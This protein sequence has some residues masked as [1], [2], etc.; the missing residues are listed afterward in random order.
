MIIISLKK[1]ITLIFRFI[2]N[3]NHLFLLLVY[4]LLLSLNQNTLN[5]N[6]WFDYSEL[7]N[8]GILYN[9]VTSVSGI[10]FPILYSV[11]KSELF[12]ALFFSLIF[13]FSLQKIADSLQIEKK[14][15][16]ISFVFF[17]FTSF[18]GFAFF[19]Y[20]ILTFI[21]IC[22]LVLFILNS[23]YLNLLYL[24][25]FT[26]FLLM[27]R[28]HDGLLILS[29]TIT[30]LL[31]HQKNLLYIIT[32]I[33]IPIVISNFILFFYDL[34]LSNYLENVIF[35]AKDAKTSSIFALLIRP[36]INIKNSLSYI[37]FY[38]LLLS[39]LSLAFIY[40]FVTI[41]NNFIIKK[42][43]FMILIVMCLINFAQF[44]LFIELV[45][46]I[47]LS[48][49]FFSFIYEMQKI[50]I[51]QY[52]NFIFKKF[53]ST[54]FF[55]LT[56][57]FSLFYIQNLSAGGSFLFCHNFILPALCLLFVILN[58]YERKHTFI[59][60]KNFT[61][62]NAKLTLFLNLFFTIFI[63]GTV[64]YK[65][66]KPY[67]WHSIL[68]PPVFISR[69]NCSVNDQSIYIDKQSCLFLHKINDLI[70]DNKTYSIMGYPFSGINRLLAK[71]LYKHHVQHFYDFSSEKEIERLIMDTTGNDPVDIIVYKY[72]LN[73]LM[74]HIQTYKGGKN[75]SNK[76][77]TYELKI[78][79]KNYTVIDFFESYKSKLLYF[80][81]VNNSLLKNEEDLLYFQKHFNKKIYTS[82]QY[83]SFGNQELNRFTCRNI[84]NINK[85]FNDP[86]SFYK[87]YSIFCNVL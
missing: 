67:E 36:I 76:H 43:F 4:V 12:V 28:I 3:F 23:C 9:D 52:L 1:E 55:L 6:I 2:S 17:I 30:F 56:L 11:L 49:Y 15:I 54:E 40:L 31:L 58:N 79:H 82:L 34:D 14:K 84:E 85:F 10:F 70:S 24:S 64:L 48:V 50:K 37:N 72:D 13:I 68:Q 81:L 62:D 80:V 20:H 66:V 5:G 83:K 45:F 44:N 33:F 65:L 61:L 75:L 18:P 71:N 78:L 87:K 69:I 22:F 38:T 26:A 27:T 57:S 35:Q 29:F 74:H 73:N 86:E 21:S 16:F 60:F 8:E 46:L 51:D 32:A 59:N 47:F 39:F 42:I 25:F 63:F 7:L 53:K 19:D 77:L 41:K